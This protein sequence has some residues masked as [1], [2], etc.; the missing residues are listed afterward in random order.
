MHQCMGKCTHEGI[1]EIQ[2]GWTW[3]RND[4]VGSRHLDVV[5]ASEVSWD[6]TPLPR[7]SQ[8]PGAK[9]QSTFPVR[10]SGIASH[11]TKLDRRSSSNRSRGDPVKGKLPPCSRSQAYVLA[12]HGFGLLQISKESE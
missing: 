10:S 5:Q 4:A 11:L 12:N 3:L 9:L 6:P 2:T 8:S 1:E 7:R